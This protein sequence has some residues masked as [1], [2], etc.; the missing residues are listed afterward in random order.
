MRHLLV[1]VAASDPVRF[2]NLK[3][4][5]LRVY[6]KRS[7]LVHDGTLPVSELIELEVEAREIALAAL[8]YSLAEA[9]TI[10]LG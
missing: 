1:R 10:G 8:R 2:G 6:D 5:G 4:R 9:H 3:I 7:V